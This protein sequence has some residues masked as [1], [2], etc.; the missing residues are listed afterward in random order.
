M[1]KTK[2]RYGVVGLGHIAQSAVLPA[3]RHANKNSVLTALVSGDPKKEKKI[4]DK[5]KIKNLFSYEEYDQ[6][7]E[8]GLVDA[9]YICLPN[10]LHHEFAKKALKKGIHVLCEKPLA[11]QQKDCL[12]LIETAEHMKVKLMTAYRLHFEPSNL[13]A[14]ELANSK[15]GELRYFNSS[16][17]FVIQDPGNIRLKNETGGGPLWDIGVYC[18]NASRYLFQAEPL[19]VFAFTSSGRGGKFQEVEESASVTMK[20]PNDRIASF[21]CS[22]GAYEIADFHLFGTKGSIHLENAYEYVTPRKLTLKNKDGKKT[23]KFS[24]VDQFAPE[25]IYFSDCILKNKNIEPSGLE[26]LADVRII[27]ALYESATTGRAVAIE[28]ENRLDRKERPSLRQ[29][30]RQPAVHKVN[31]ISVR[32]PSGD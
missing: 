12:D 5:L 20:F 6:F 31:T 10:H 32:S 18:L 27:E 8:S 28:R 26:G 22:Y 2:I 23:F 7:L 1:K 19:E 15:I 30:Y 13:K 17:S 14:I 16:F 11:I 4:G 29:K 9:V 3:F 21:V 24:K 25:I